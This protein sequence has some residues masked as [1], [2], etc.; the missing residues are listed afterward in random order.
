M[1]SVFLLPL[2]VPLV[3]VVVVTPRAIAVITVGLDKAD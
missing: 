1:S 3:F 2:T